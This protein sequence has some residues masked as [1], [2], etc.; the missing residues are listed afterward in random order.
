[1]HFSQM[2]SEKKKAFQIGFSEATM[3]SVLMTQT[4]IIRQQT[5]KAL[6]KP[7]NIIVQCVS[8]F[9]IVAGKTKQKKRTKTKQQ[10]Q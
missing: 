5:L 7:L 2:L 3:T 10:Q 4:E 1:M 9:V 8:N 6:K